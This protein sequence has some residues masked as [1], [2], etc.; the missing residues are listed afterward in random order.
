MERTVF[1]IQHRIKTHIENTPEMEAHWR[2]RVDAERALLQRLESCLRTLHFDKHMN[3]EKLANTTV[4]FGSRSGVDLLGRIGLRLAGTDEEWVEQLLLVDPERIDAIKDG[5]AERYDLEKRFSDSL[6]IAFV[7]TDYSL[8]ASERYLQFIN[9]LID[10]V[11]VSKM[12]LPKAECLKLRVLDSEI[13]S[14]MST[15]V[16]TCTIALPICLDPKDVLT[17]IEEQRKDL[18]EAFE[19]INR[20]QHE[21]N[22]LILAA[23]RKFRLRALTWDP[24]VS[25]HQLQISVTNLIRY[26]TQLS[27]MLEHQRV[28]IAFDYHL[29]DSD[30]TINVRWDF[31][32]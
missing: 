25:T 26:A 5:S 6:G 23:K 13:K 20:V 3:V 22:M 29:D 27:R 32:V 19:K 8:G 28:R 18:V 31:M 12:H 17:K 21:L 10:A 4:H 14:N 16:S 15:D 9:T 2:T 11:A 30:G 1:Y 24:Q 7:Y